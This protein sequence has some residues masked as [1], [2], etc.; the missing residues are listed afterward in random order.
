VEGTVKCVAPA[1]D[2]SEPAA[3]AEESTTK[4]KVIM[5]VARAGGKAPDF[6][7]M[8][9]HEGGFKQVKLSDYAGQWTCICFYPGDFTFV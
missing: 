7:G 4:G 6:Q 1:G 9:Y 5:D 8:A 3:P 2:V